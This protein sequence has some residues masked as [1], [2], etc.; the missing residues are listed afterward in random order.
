[1]EDRMNP[2]ETPSDET[3]AATDELFKAQP[4]A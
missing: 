4:G 3:I 1:M 2:S